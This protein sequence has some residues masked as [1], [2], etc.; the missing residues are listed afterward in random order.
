MVS[1]V[2]YFYITRMLQLTTYINSRANTNR[3]SLKISFTHKLLPLSAN[4]IVHIYT[5]SIPDI[6]DI[7]L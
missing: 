4:L 5:V 6:K 2:R 7:Y 1:K 3:D